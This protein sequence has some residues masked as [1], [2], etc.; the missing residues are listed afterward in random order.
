MR[1]SARLFTSITL[2]VS[3]PAYAQTGLLDQAEANIAVG[4]TADAR[5]LL[6]K[7]Q[8][9]GSNGARNNQEEQARFHAL[10]ARTFMHADNA[11]D[12]YLTVALN[13][14]TAKPAPEAL[15]RLA[16]ADAMRGDTARALGYLERLLANYPNSEQLPLARQWQTR[17]R[18]A[19]LAAKTSSA[20]NTVAP[21]DAAKSSVTNGSFAIQVGAFREIAGARTMK[22]QLE[23]AGLDDVRLVRV[24]DNTLIR[25]RVGNYAN[26][27]A[28]NTTLSRLQAKK[29]TGV[30]VN[31]AD[32]ESPVKQ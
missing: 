17:L 24:P 15:L 10:L 1:I 14:P 9:E 31:D 21:N 27:A 19:A 29:F 13:Y 2:L 30:V 6:Q 8:R 32:K 11:Q 3:A 20:N 26:R 28:A 4:A 22:Q 12:H 16:Q 7:W 5:A 23:R 25:V 18:P